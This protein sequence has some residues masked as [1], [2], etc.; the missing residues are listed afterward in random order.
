MNSLVLIPGKAGL[1]YTRVCFDSAG[2]CDGTPAA[3]DDLCGTTASVGDIQAVLC[4]TRDDRPI[5]V[6]T[7]RAIFGGRD[8]SSPIIVDRENQSRLFRLGA[9]SPMSVANTSALVANTRAAFPKIPI[10]L[11][12]ETS[13]FVDL[14]HRE[15]TYAL[16][17][18]AGL[19]V[20][21]WGYHGLFHDAATSQL[22][23]AL[24]CDKRPPRM[25]SIC[26][27]S[28]PEMA[29]VLGRT[30]LTVTSGSTPMDGLPG[31][32][33]CGEIDPSIALALACDP[34][35]GPEHANLLLTRE[36]GFLGMLGW[37][38]TLGEVLTEKRARVARVREHLL[39]H[40]ALAAGTS[41]A[42]LEGLDG[43]VFS[44]RYAEHADKV[45]SYL[46]PRLERTL[47]LPAHSLPW[48]ICR[49]P[50]ETLVAEAGISALIAS[51]WPRQQA[52]PAS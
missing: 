20:R 4:A 34:A 28:Q 9:Q 36:S 7:I 11:A 41:L 46:V 6:L 38:A 31:E 12:F 15:T 47:A 2:L 39:Y 10:A 13:F 23:K 19:P 48:Q 1:R 16:P 51:G 52:L 43:V 29:A 42:A 8:F 18:T 49:A 50:L 40:M 22:A 33:N 24:A 17:I 32:C 45:A 5:D 35:L 27:D 26:L 21:R 44:G 25:L 14:P 30:P 37:P 3:A